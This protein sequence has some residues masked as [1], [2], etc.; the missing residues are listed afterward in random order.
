MMLGF[1]VYPFTAN[2]A[3]AE[4]PKKITLC[5][6]IWIWF[7][8]CRTLFDK[9]FGGCILSWSLHLYDIGTG[10]QAR[11][12]YPFWSWL[13]HEGS[14]YTIHAHILHRCVSHD[15]DILAAGLNF[16]QST[17]LWNHLSYAIRHVGRFGREISRKRCF[18]INVERICRVERNNLPS[19]TPAY[20]LG[21]AQRLM[22][23]SARKNKSF[24]PA[25]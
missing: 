1:E 17:A 7:Y 15:V 10:G 16:D 9:N 13:G 23:F 24:T 19:F 8:I 22:S 25:S 18:M 20:K 6:F 2:A 5:L 14:T 12:G 4:H 21:I 3:S 11:N